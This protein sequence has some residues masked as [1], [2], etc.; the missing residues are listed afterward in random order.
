M[1][2]ELI[3]DEV[4]Q[5]RRSVGWFPAPDVASPL[6]GKF[7]M[8]YR[9]VHVR[10]V[11][12]GG[13]AYE[14]PDFSVRTDPATKRAADSVVRAVAACTEYASG[15]L[16][17]DVC[18]FIT[19][20][21]V[22]LL[23]YGRVVHEV[24]NGDDGQAYF[25]PLPPGRILSLGPRVAQLV[26]PNPYDKTP[27]RVVWLDRRS[28]W[29]LTPPAGLGGLRLAWLRHVLARADSIPPGWW[30]QPV[31][32]NVSDFDFNG[33]VYKTDIIVARAVRAWGWP[34]PHP[35]DR[36]MTNF[37]KLREHMRFAIAM[38]RTREHVLAELNRQL[39][40]AARPVQI[41]MDGLPDSQELETMFR[42][43]S[44]GDVAFGEAIATTRW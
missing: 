44:G 36:Q 20:E 24:V 3:P 39:V 35:A 30:H 26:P 33:F 25:F 18:D 37:H 31:G 34:V 16:Q 1:R 28:L 40:H 5:R 9:D 13:R 32:R 2:R 8:F 11:P 21:T 10:V 4:A 19:N 7:F 15:D 29:W 41:A 6:K 27:R 38:A 14:R 42:R 17:S 43:F 23:L 22:R 12:Y